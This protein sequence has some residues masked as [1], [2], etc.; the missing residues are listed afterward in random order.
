MTLSDEATERLADVVELQPT[1][2]AD[3]QERWGMESGS[4]VHQYLE[5]ELGDY[6]FRD[7]NSLIRATAE[8]ADLVDVE[9]GIESDPDEEGA[10]SRIRV[11]EL[12][13]RIVEVLAGPDEE[14]E[15]VVSVLHSLREAYDYG[16]DL[17]AEDVRSGLQ[18]LRRKDV[19]E[20]EYRTVPT[21]RLA[22][23]REDLEVDVTD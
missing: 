11:P 4:E 16:D 21:F 7:D 3:L 15:S 13:A 2:N 10:P 14:S 1:K 19:V 22:V 12:Q 18:R 9:P 17:E 8:A 20:V 6:Y 5:N 23:E